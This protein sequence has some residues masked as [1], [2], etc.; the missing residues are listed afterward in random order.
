MAQE[1]AIK[2]NGRQKNDGT[3][4]E[5]KREAQGKFYN[6]QGTYYL[7]YEG[8]GDLAGVTTTLKIKDRRVTLIR[9][10]AVRTKQ[11]FIPQARTSFDYQ[12]PYGTLQL[13][14]EV[15]ELEVDIGAKTGEVD[16]KYLLY[17][18]E[19]LVGTNWLNI[20]YKEE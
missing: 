2:V 3:E 11:E 7:R 16:L 15:E 19:G 5:I 8:E 18:P 6:K 14:V 17:D 9:Q 12:T 1:V 13:E 10:G 4:T 20:S